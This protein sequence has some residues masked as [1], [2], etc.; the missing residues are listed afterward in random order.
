MADH[1]KP[2][3]GNNYVNVLADIR[4]KFDDQARMF[5][6]TLTDPTNL[7]IGAVGWAANKWVKWGGESWSDLAATYAINISG[8]A[9][10]V[11][12]T[13]AL[14]R[15]GTGATTAALAR[16]NLG[17]EATIVPGTVAQYWRGD[18]MLVNLAADVLATPLTGLSFAIGTPIVA[19]DSIVVSFG[20]LQKGKA[21][22]DSPEFIKDPKAP[23]A[24]AGDNDSSIA[25][26][27]FVERAVNGI[28]AI[29]VGGGTDTMLTVAHA[30]YGQLR[31]SGV[32]TAN[33]SVIFPSGKSGKWVIYNDT[34]G[35][36]SITMKTASGDGVTINQGQKKLVTTDGTN[37]YDVAGGGGGLPVGHAI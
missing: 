10:N 23:T 6:P 29:A 12:G 33:K 32:L 20:K 4:D 2:L 18:K 5:D 37:F 22:L 16:V 30:G 21:D 25:N 31:L 36:F 27:A 14:N 19:T 34:T 28:F 9:S 17:A 3:A 15:G 7:P 1:S 13:V 26:T 11:T 8:T 35:G 24:A